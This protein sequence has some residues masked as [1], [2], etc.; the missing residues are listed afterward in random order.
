MAAIA[1]GGIQTALKL[2]ISALTQHTARVA[3][4]T[5]ENAALAQIAP[6]IEQDLQEIAAAVNSGQISASDAISAISQVD[7]QTQEYL[8]KQLGKPGTAWNAQY[9]G[10]V[11][12]VTS[13]PQVN[14]GQGVA[15]NKSCTVGCCI[16]FNSWKPAFIA[17]STLLQGTQSGGRFSVTV[18]A[19]QSNK[20]GFPGFPAYT[21]S[22]QIP[23]AASISSIESTVNDA[24][25]L[26][27]GN[28]SNSSVSSS[29]KSGSTNI[30]T[31]LVIGVASTIL[32][33]LIIGGRKK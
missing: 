18:L 26:L 25:N 1:I 30:T 8:Q 4:A 22:V 27:T 29:V 15:C 20:Y 12:N 3:G 14:M 24:A 17:M 32:G 33:A 9:N 21:I 13:N 28:T 16:Y 7:Q 5:N 10:P 11:L 6:A 31:L 23:S 19:M 2:G